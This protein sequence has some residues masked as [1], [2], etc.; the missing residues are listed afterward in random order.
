VPSRLLA[1]STDQTV[2]WALALA[3]L[4][5]W[6]LAVRD[7]LRRDD[8]TTTTKVVWGAVVIVLGLVGVVLYFLFR[9]RGATQAERDARQQASDEFVRKHT[10][11]PATPATPA[12]PADPASTDVPP[13]DP[14]GPAQSS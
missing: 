5:G 1:A 7:L 3:T 6:F 14:P 10:A 8:A 13:V 12:S 9:P 2:V 4:V 11:P